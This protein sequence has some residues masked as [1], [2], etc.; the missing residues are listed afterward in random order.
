MAR[1][2]RGRSLVRGFRRG[3]KVRA[4]GRRM[5]SL[6]ALLFG[7]VLANAVP[8]LEHE[9]QALARLA[10]HFCLGRR[11]EWRSTREVHSGNTLQQPNP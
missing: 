3:A 10:G 8:A 6:S 5:R 4:D 7:Y 2:A 1:A 11:V 9:T